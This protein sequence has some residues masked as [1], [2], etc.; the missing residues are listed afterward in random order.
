MHAFCAA[1]ECMPFGA[2]SPPAVVCCGAMIKYHAVA[3]GRVAGFIQYEE[4]LKT[5]DHACAVICVNE[6]GGSATDAAGASVRFP[7]RLFQVE[8]GVVCAS[9]YASAEVRQ[10]LLQA[11]NEC[12]VG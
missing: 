4:E 11:V 8:G 6:S 9:K 12:V 5:W 7:G 10:A 3:A 2:E 1:S